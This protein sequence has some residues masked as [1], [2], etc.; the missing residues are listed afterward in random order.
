MFLFSEILIDFKA[1]M[2]VFDASDD[3][4]KIGSSDLLE[5]Y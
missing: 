4:I 1:L 5:N 3:V 2:N